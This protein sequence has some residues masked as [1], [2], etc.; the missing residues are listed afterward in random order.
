MFISRSSHSEIVQ[1]SERRLADLK[2]AHDQ[3]LQILQ[4]QIDGLT[5]ERDFY[6]DEWVKLH[7]ARFTS[8]ASTSGEPPAI[9]RP[10]IDLEVDT[11]ASW[12]IDDR[13][14]FNDW[15]RSRGY[16]EEE[17]KEAWRREYGDEPPILAL[18]V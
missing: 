17:A 12:L 15:A 13:S 18:T 8:A 5:A 7:G 4:A 16:G 14:L 3:A 11:S 6:R 1:G 9:E 10:A 2:A